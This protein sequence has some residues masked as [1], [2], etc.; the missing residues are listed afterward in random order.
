MTQF[1]TSLI[2]LHLDKY[3]PK[4]KILDNIITTAALHEYRVVDSNSTKPWGAYV[5]FDGSSAEKFVA[6]FFPRLSI[7]EA[8]LGIEKAELSPKILLVLPGERLSWQ[9]HHRRAERWIFLTEG[10]YYKSGTDEQGELQIAKAG[11]VVQFACGERHRLVGAT[12]SYTLVAE[13]WQH[14]DA[15][16][17]SDEADIVRLADDYE[18]IV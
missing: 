14:V 17:L 15:T 18:R 12:D 7:T 1:K 11:D 16:E 6:E 9:L 13:I 5:R 8:R 4:G 3:T 2:Q 10:G